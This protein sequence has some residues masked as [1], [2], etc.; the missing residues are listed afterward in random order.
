MSK[1]TAVQQLI[2]EA[3]WTGPDLR[4]WHYRDQD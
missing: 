2:A 4:Y 1:S 3:G